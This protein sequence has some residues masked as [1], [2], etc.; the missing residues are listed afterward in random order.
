MKKPTFLLLAGVAL[1]VLGLL[2][3][4]DFWYPQN[5]RTLPAPL[6]SLLIFGPAITVAGLA[7]ALIGLVGLVKKFT[8]ITPKSP[9]EQ[10]QRQRIHPPPLTS[11]NCV[12]GTQIRPPVAGHWNHDG[13]LR[14][15]SMVV[16]GHS[17]LAGWRTARQRRDRPVWFFYHDDF[18]TAGPVIDNH[19]RVIPVGEKIVVR[20]QV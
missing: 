9:A 11:Q 10:I 1:L 15:V 6:Q 16:A 19:Q 12:A 5:A 2:L 20:L 4:R 18:W 14:P 7:L 8:A 17:D 3:L 13:Y